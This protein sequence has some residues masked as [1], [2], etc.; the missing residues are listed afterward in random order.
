MIQIDRNYFPDKSSAPDTIWKFLSCE[1][2]IAYFQINPLFPKI[3]QVFCGDINIQLHEYENLL[4][5][6]RAPFSYSDFYYTIKWF[7]NID[8]PECFIC[9]QINQGNIVG[10][11]TDFTLLP[12]FIW[13]NDDTHKN[14]P[15]YSMIVGYDHEN[16]IITDAPNLIKQKFYMKNHTSLVK[17][18]ILNKLFEKNCSCL[19]VTCNSSFPS[20]F[21]IIE[22]IEQI[23]KTYFS[24]PDY[25]DS[26]IIW[27]GK[28][29]LERFIELMNEEDPRI[30]SINL[31][32]GPFIATIISGRRELLRR[33][34]FQYYNNYN[35]YKQTIDIL[36]KN[37]EKWE[38]LAN[39]IQK[40][41]IKYGK[42][43]P[44][45]DVF[46]TLYKIESET[47]SI[48]IQLCEEIKNE[49]S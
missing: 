26:H 41:I 48:L 38:I 6:S 33:C 21:D 43:T 19:I 8:S 20:G 18:D 44:N 24:L 28:L 47:I 17:K 9:S 40:H 15:H 4:S 49:Y 22:I 3:E 35:F 12:N 30:P 42:Y 32:E 16:Y 11:N 37:A 29:A 1:E 39:S 23:K 7:N 27:N 31:F 5:F 25:Q 2:K 13:Y 46:K 45:L 14:S 10:I 36:T 34:I